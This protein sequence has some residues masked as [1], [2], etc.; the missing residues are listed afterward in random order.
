M[1]DDQVSLTALAQYEVGLDAGW[2]S[3]RN[4]V[5]G[6]DNK[7]TEPYWAGVK[8]GRDAYRSCVSNALIV[9]RP[10]TRKAPL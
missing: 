5:F 4:G 1:P 2:A 6:P 10:P 7:P 8:Q 3:Q 9:D